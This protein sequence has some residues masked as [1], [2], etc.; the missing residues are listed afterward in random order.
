[1]E[2]DLYYKKGA[3]DDNPI[4]YTFHTI[5][6]ITTLNLL[7]VSYLSAMPMVSFLLSG[8]VVVNITI[9]HMIAQRKRSKAIY[10]QGV[11]IN[12]IIFQI[13]MYVSGPQAPSWILLITPIVPCALLVDRNLSRIVIALTLASFIVIHNAHFD[14]SYTATLTELFFFATIVTFMLRIRNHVEK[15]K[16]NIIKEQKKSDYLLSCILPTP[17]I[18]RI[19]R[20]ETNF[21]ENV[22]HTTFLFV[23]ICQ[24]TQFVEKSTGIQVVNFLNT[25]FS[26][27]DILVEEEKLTKI[28]TLGD[29]YLVAGGLFEEDAEQTKKI[30]NLSIN[31]LRA[32]EQ[33]N[34]NREDKVQIRIGIASGSS[35]IGIIGN[36][37][38][39]FDAWGDSVNT[40]S[41]M[42][43]T[44][45]PGKIQVTEKVYNVLKDD[46][47][48][49]AR[50]EMEIKGKG[51]M[52]TYFLLDYK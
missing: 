41:R 28:K 5:L 6:G 22:S 32:L 47:Q 3:S 9:H 7:F 1:M 29:A 49:E 25:I 11:F 31:M 13:I 45:I 52:N 38:I 50:G 24:Y 23:D 8:L 4:L 43:T 18:E 44:S 10:L 17:I 35:T 51:K 39:A 15:Q 33:V 34:T 36:N 30:A 46:Y 26:I 37:H 27:F 16:Q 20:G 21:A 40:A 48:F 14:K 2:I 42:E 12:V 19:K